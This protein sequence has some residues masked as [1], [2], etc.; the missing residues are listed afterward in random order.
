MHAKAPTHFELIG[1]PH[2]TKDTYLKSWRY[3]HALTPK[4]LNGKAGHWRWT[5]LLGQ[6]PATLPLPGR[7]LAG[8]RDTLA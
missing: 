1:K 3:W 4:I 6:H 2:S 7:L 8:L 5:G